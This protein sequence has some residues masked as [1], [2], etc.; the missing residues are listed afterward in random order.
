MRPLT[1]SG[2]RLP[3]VAHRPP[4]GSASCLSDLWNRRYQRLAWLFGR[5]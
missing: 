1:D 5:L 3:T 4:R 2:E